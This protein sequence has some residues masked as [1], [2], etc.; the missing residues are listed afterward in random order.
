MAEPITEAQV[1]GLKH[2]RR[3]SPLLERLRDVGCARDRAG[4]RTLF[5]DGYCKLVLLYLFNPLIDSVQALRA[6]AALPKVTKTLGVK[7][8]SAGSFS[9][10]V[11]V[12]EPARLK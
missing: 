1:R 11:R 3:L 8:F 7:R 10:S 5:F 9:E 12:F 4:N 6:A 2:F